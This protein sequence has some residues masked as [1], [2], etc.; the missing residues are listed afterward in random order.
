[1]SGLLQNNKFAA[2]DR[3]RHFPDNMNRELPVLLA[4]D[5]EY[6][7]ILDSSQ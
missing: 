6:R 7:D 4:C 1:M 3:I 5:D 2:L